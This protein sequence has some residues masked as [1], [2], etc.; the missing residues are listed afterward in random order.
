MGFYVEKGKIIR[1]GKRVKDHPLKNREA[2][3][4][5]RRGALSLCNKYKHKSGKEFLD[6]DSDGDISLDMISELPKWGK[7]FNKAFEESG[8]FPD[9]ETIKFIN[10]VYSR[11][12]KDYRRA[13]EELYGWKG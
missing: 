5:L 8:D 3:E 10:S 4:Q 13:Y 1:T 11:C 7:K 12:W 6:L 9:F 2:R